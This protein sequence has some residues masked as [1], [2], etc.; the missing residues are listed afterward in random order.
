MMNSKM[1]DHHLARQ[2]CIYIRQSTPGQVRFNQESKERQYNL[3]NQAKALGWMPEQIRILDG[4]LGHSG[5]QATHRDDFKTL[6]SDVAMGQVGAIFSLEASRL[7]RSNKDWHRLLELCAITKTLVFDGDGCYDPADFND[8]LVLGIKGQFA[9]AELHIIRARLHGAKL[10]KAQKGE[11]RFPLPVGLVYDDDKI[12]LDPD[13]EVQGAV[14]SVFELFEQENSAYRVVQRFHQLGLRF[15][16]RAYGGAWDGKLIWGRLTHSRVIGVLANPC[17]AGTYVFGRHQSCKKI[18]ATGEICSRSRRVPEDQ[19]RVV[20]PDHHPG[21]ITRDQFLANRKR[22]ADNRTNIETLAG[23]AREGLCLLQGLLLCGICGRRLTVRYTGNGG[24]YP[25]Y[26]CNWRTRDGL[27]L[28][29][30]MSLAAGPLDDAITERVLTAVTPLTIKLALEALTGLEERDRLISAQWHRRIERARYEAELAE[31]RYEEVD[32]SNRLIASTLEK[33]WNDAMQRMA[34]L[35]AEL[36]AFERQALRSVTAEQKRQILQ[37]GR[38]F[39][40]L[41]KARTTSACDRKRMLRLLIRDITVAKG[42][43]PKLLRL[44]VCWQGGAN[45]TIE[46][47]QRPKRQD[48]IRYPD[49]FVAKIRDMAKLYRDAE[50]IDLLKSE[51]LTSSTGK[52]FTLSMIRWIRHKHHIPSPL[53]PAGTLTVGQVCQRYG[54]SLWVVHY[55]IERGIVSAVHHKRNTPYAITINADVDRRLREWVANSGHLRRVTPN[56]N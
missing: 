35:E 30:C 13:Q 1:A 32:P 47:R 11:L 45:E 38:D 33:R 44:Q 14:R 40:R 42:P 41:W 20:I 10:N 9:Q 54:V 2:A 24:L 5:E 27:P 4:D 52:P 26:E 29:H 53:P 15:P 28:R 50:I 8:G 51:G 21:Y 3:A 16:R 56:A 25:I 55:W 36:A 31:R 12:V 6:V 18:D 43:E 48:A 22:L 39:P 46:V 37:L 7:A 34:D 19:W 23:P 17:Y 49:T